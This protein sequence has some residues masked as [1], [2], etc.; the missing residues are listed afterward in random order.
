MEENLGIKP[1]NAWINDPF[2]YSSDTSL[3]LV[4]SD[5]EERLT[6]AI[7]QAREA[8]ASALGLMLING[9][10]SSI[11]ALKHSVDQDGPRSLLL[12]NELKFQGENLKIV[13]ANPAEHAREDVVC[14][15]IAQG[16]VE[17]TDEE[18]NI[19]QYQAFEP[20]H[21][22]YN[23]LSIL[24]FSVQLLPYEVQIF[25]ISKSATGQN[26]AI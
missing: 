22:T 26:G 6:N 14:V 21:P 16:N 4:V 7:R 15:C 17:V 10:V 23:Q 25:T 12:L 13:V 2:G 18:G 8:L 5:N 9:S 24:S 11:T 1:V 20:T 19:T 3:P